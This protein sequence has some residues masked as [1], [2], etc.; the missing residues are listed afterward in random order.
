MVSRL[1]SALDARVAECRDPLEHICLRAERAALLARQ[2]HLEEAR[3]ELAA[4]NARYDKRPNALVSAWTNF[5]EGLVIY[6]SSLDGAAR[7]KLKRSLALS[8]AVGA[9][10]IQPLSAAWLAQMDFAS[11]DFEPM[12]KHIGTSL[13]HA[14]PEHHSARSRACLVTAGAYHW[15]ERV[16]L[17]LPWYERA[18][19]HATAEGD[20]PTISAL[21]HNMA[22]LRTAEARRQSVEGI[23]NVSEARQALLV[24]DS[25]SHF[26]AFIGMTALGSLVPILRAQ[27]LVVQERYA[28]A[29]ELLEANA[30]Q[31]E[32]EGLERM[33]CVMFADAAWCRLNI[34]DERG[35]C[36]D[37]RVA[38]SRIAVGTHIDDRAMTHSR[39]A[40]IYAA[41]DK[42][43][44]ARDHASQASADWQLVTQRQEQLVAAMTTALTGL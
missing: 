44:E 3:T 20:Q 21:M 19:R 33:A 7:D 43:E 25:T 26:D 42:P 36:R 16:D 8:E 24:A 4:I 37:A 27:V 23:L 9:D 1:L 18:R 28:D 30:E 38:L 22:W 35:A 34:G 13:R 29:L 41:I 40:A 39:L 17:A 2:G 11:L 5:A 31:S 10:L 14:G 32:K 15:A 12:M 6:F